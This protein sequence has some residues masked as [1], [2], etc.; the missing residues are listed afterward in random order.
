MTH[1]SIFRRAGSEVETY[2]GSTNAD[3]LSYVDA[4]VTN[5]IR[6]YYRVTASTVFGEGP[7]S[8]EVSA[9]PSSSILPPEIPVVSQPLLWVLVA[10]FALAVAVT[11]ARA[12]K[13]RK[14]DVG[15]GTG[16]GDLVDAA[17]PPPDRPPIA[18]K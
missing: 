7:R 6:Y 16:S 3:T 13:R 5:D 18:P 9:V 4:D 2:I 8:E 10:I 12:L 11:L 1:F 15:A 14:R 17:P